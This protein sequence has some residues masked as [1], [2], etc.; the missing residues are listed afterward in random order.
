[1]GGR[2]RLEYPT[3][4]V[5]FDIPTTGQITGPRFSPGGERILFVER[6]S[7]NTMAGSLGVIDLSSG[8]KILTTNSYDTVVSPAWSPEG[9]EIWFSDGPRLRAVTLSGKERLVHASSGLLQLC[10]I[11]RGGRLLMNSRQLRFGINALVPGNTREIDLSWLDK[12]YA[13]DLSPDGT[14]L[15]FDES[16]EGG[17]PNESVYVRRTDG[18]PAVRLG[19]GW[20]TALTPDGK[21]ALTL[22]PD[23]ESDVVFMPTGA[24]EARVISYPEKNISLVRSFPDG[25]HL[26]LVASEKGHGARLWVSDMSGNNLRS[27]SSE[28]VDSV[29][30]AVSPDGGLAAATGTDGLPRLYPV[31][32]GVPRPVP[33]GLARD[34]PIRFSADGRFLYA[35]LRK[36]SAAEI[37]RLDLASGRRELWKSLAPS[38]RGGYSP[39][40]A[41][42]ITP[43]G[44]FYAY[45]YRRVLSELFIADGLR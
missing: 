13:N 23:R 2:C 28:G 6:P 33:G 31:E 18:S 24:G 25:R 40:T 8:R 19:D 1:M 43:D 27:I 42:Q 34:I 22:Q 17:G 32:G 29:G 10:D 14:V 45:T 5:L 7:R 26:L 21:W 38:D 11:S 37:S 39:S 4:K 3:G 20:A 16:G 30:A 15:L 12:S 9:N 35:L 44:R 41:A 36:Q